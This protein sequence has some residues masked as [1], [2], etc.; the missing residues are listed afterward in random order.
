MIYR[1]AC[2]KSKSV[3]PH[4]DG[5]VKTYICKDCIDGSLTI[6]LKLLCDGAKYFRPRDETGRRKRLKISGQ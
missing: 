4:R 5:R 2:G 1:C 3:Q 6:R